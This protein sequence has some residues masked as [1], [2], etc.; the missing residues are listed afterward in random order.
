MLRPLLRRHLQNSVGLRATVERSIHLLR[1][2]VPPP[3]KCIESCLST[4]IRHKSSKEFEELDKPIQ[5]T[6][7]KASE[8]RA[9]QSFGGTIPEDT[10]DIQPISV[11]LSIAAFLIYFCVL[12]EEND[13][14]EEMKK[15]LWERIPGLERQQ[16]D[17]VY[18]Y[19][20]Q[21][22]IVNT[23]ILARIKELDDKTLAE[24]AAAKKQD[25]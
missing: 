16:L 24:A 23:A 14:D 7:S 11:M 22:G 5:F 18:D 17:V 19:N 20:E 4:P 8:W 15:S 2:N 12:R 9:Q 3:S 6:S 25:A 21:H 13:I 10:P 1:K